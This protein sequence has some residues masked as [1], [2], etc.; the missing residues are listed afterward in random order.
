MTQSRHSGTS[1]HLTCS[2]HPPTAQERFLPAS[3]LPR[4]L[5]ALQRGCWL[6]Q[7]GQGGF[8]NPGHEQLRSHPGQN[9][10][11]NPEGFGVCGV[12]PHAGTGPPAP[13][14]SPHRNSQGRLPGRSPGKRP[15]LPGGHLR[16]G[17]SPS[18]AFPGGFRLSL[19]LRL[20]GTRTFVPARGSRRLLRSPRDPRGIE[21]T[22]GAGT[23]PAPSASS[24]HTSDVHFQL[25]IRHQFSF[26]IISS[27]KKSSPKNIK[28]RP[29][30]GKGA[31]ERPGELQPRSRSGPLFLVRLNS[32]LPCGRFRNVYPF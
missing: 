22:P 5:G 12:Q 9:R 19:F 15:P 2:P 23:G 1:L 25:K 17:S 28:H 13:A 31:P 20:P 29:R 18:S 3:P 24:P 30:G 11:R 14:P 10:P 16:P 27:S 6:G 8:S 7:P 32:L 26:G 4:L 21:H